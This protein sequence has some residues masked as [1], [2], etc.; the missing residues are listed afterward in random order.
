MET[1]QY[2]NSHEVSLSLETFLVEWK[3]SGA[4]AEELEALP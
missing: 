1:G 3:L 2:P 4:T